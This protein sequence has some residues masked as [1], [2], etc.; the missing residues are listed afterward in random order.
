MTMTV[1]PAQQGSEQWLADR[2]ER[3][4]AGDAAAMLGCDPNGR[5]RTDLLDAMVNGF[6]PEVGAFKQRLY[7][8]GAISGSWKGVK[9]KK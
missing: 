5:T 3:Y 8:K 9:V 2:A 1:H 4:N 7:D 6:S